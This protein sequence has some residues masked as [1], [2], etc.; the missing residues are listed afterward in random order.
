VHPKTGEKVWFN[1]AVTLNSATLE[2]RLREMLCKLF[3]PEDLPNNTFFGD[4]TPIEAKELEAVR[5]AYDAEEVMFSW[6]QGDV[7][8]LDN[9]LV[10]HARRPYKGK[11]KVVVGMADPLTRETTEVFSHVSS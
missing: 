2:P 1:H 7:L 9:M 4:G 11:R 3:K 8:M 10:A 5:S 6:Q